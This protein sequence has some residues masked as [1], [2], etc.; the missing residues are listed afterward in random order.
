MNDDRKT[1]LVV[2]P[3]P[4]S[5]TGG[6]ASFIGFQLDNSLLSEQ[7][8]L[9]C[10]DI[11]LSPLLRSGKILRFTGSLILISRLLWLLISEGPALVHIHSS[12]QLSFWEKGLMLLVC[13]ALRKRTVL[14]MHGAMFDSFYD[15]SRL[16]PIIRL[17]LNRA[18]AMIVLTNYWK[19]FCGTIT[20]TR[21]E[22]VP[23]C[24][25]KD[26]FGGE[27]SN[28]DGKSVVF[29]GEIGPRKGVDVL[30][31]AVELLRARG[32]DNPFILAGGE[33]QK[34]GIDKYRAQVARNNLGEVT[35][36]GNLNTSELVELLDQAAVFCLPSWA[37]GLP[38]AMLE[39]MAAG[40][41]VVAT[42][43]GG[44]PDALE[45]GINGY[46]V[47]V[48]NSTLLADRLELLLGDPALREETGQANYDKAR[49]YYHPQATA[50]ALTGL[51]NSLLR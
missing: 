20:R 18:D 33:H 23:N 31:E 28:P 51:Y 39:A 42:P 44:I 16:K 21:L 45:E 15:N 38:I 25:K 49:T 4:V 50:K 5:L 40:L 19:K 13:N 11:S 30:L 43:V 27:R 14:H 8:R 6:I 24:P 29:T 36:T 41:P 9:I 47:P 35:F 37:E 1:V 34:N 3:D 12:S 2:G 7:F 17:I 46:L 10:L 26:F 22:I 48:G 32:L